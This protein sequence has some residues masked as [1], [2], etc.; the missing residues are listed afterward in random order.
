M[1]LA[2][3]L[4]LSQGQ[5]MNLYEE[6]VLLGPVVKLDCVGAGIVCDIPSTYRGR[7][8]VAGGC[9]SGTVTSVSV[10]T[11]NGVSAIVTDPT[12][13]A[14]LA[15]TLGAITPSS[16]AASGTVTGSNLSG[17]NTGDQTKT[18]TNQFMRTLVAGASSTC[19]GVAI[20]DHT[21]TGTPSAT[22]FYRGDNT[23]AT[24]AGGSG[25]SYAEA[26]AATLAGF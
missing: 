4:A 26:S 10:T 12:V 23:W 1:I 25:I 18:C 15:F 20:A 21:A 14:A 9:G 6:G 2:L 16:V 22:T 11:Q 5:V 3:L 19:E 7:I 24:P 17:T 13:A 8:T